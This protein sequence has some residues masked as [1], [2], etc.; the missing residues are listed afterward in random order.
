[1][2]VLKLFTIS[3]VSKVDVL[4]IIT[5]I[6]YTKILFKVVKTLKIVY[7]FKLVNFD[8]SHVDFTLLHSMQQK[9]FNCKTAH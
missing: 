6:V 5:T 2:Y 1:M 9:L 4:Y 3:K 8:I 7:I